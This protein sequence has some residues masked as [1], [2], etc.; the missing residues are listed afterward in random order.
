[1]GLGSVGARESSIAILV[2][3]VLA[4]ALL[5]AP[6]LSVPLE[7]D[8]GEY[9]YIA[10]RLLE[11]D[12][13]YRDA[14]D[15]KPP[16]VFFAYALAISVGGASAEAIRGFAALFGAATAWILFLL[17]RR[18]DDEVAASC[19]VLVFA[20]AAC[21]P[22]L[23]ATAANTEQFMLLPLVAAMY[24]A[25]RGLEFG[26]RGWWLA[27]GAASAIACGFKQVAI[28]NAVFVAALAAFPSI[29]GAAT[30]N[31]ATSTNRVFPKPGR[32]LLHFA[33]GAGLASAPVLLW[34][35][36]V[37]AFRPFLDAVLI[38]NLDYAA[39]QGVL[40][41]LRNLASALAL[42]APSFAVFWL[43][44]LTALVRP[45][46]LATRTQRI[47]AGWLLAS[48]LGVS[49]GLYFRAHYF[50]Q[51][52]PALSALVGIASAGLLRR[53]LGARTALWQ[54]RSAL[55]CVVLALA[56]PPLLARS[57]LLGASPDEISRHIY[58]M[59]PFPEVAKIA[60]YL[61]GIAEPDDRVFVVGSEPQLFFYSGLRSASRFIFF[62]PLTGPYAEAGQ[63]QDEVLKEVAAA[64]PD[65]VVWFNLSTSLRIAP[66]APQRI[67]DETRTR[68][69]REYEL[70]LLARP[71]ADGEPYAFSL[72]AAAR[73][74]AGE[75]GWWTKPWISVYRLRSNFQ[76][77][78]QSN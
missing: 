76:P 62:Y 50:V 70:T 53:S 49:M 58:G 77:N 24:C 75:A 17:V 16:L 45:K 48:A 64:R 30:R 73:A 2:V 56:A 44:A 42:Q 39:T 61:R 66:G 15:Q 10:A 55:G 5:R 63:R 41:S 59:N 47:L 40:Q 37:G 14:F 6:L 46:A 35:A 68:L 22:A 34:F 57:D 27:C 60:D 36:A 25:L 31:P 71:V 12:V 74:I 4:F 32:A 7:R 65:F 1:M 19:S 54:R 11:G 51:L 52:L 67:F 38:H 72:G 43:L 8:E 9:A 20:L 28:A 23:A 26:G 78:S 18:L 3:A 29:A 13:P 33:A 69:E 21:D